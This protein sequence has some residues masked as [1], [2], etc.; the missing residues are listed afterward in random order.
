VDEVSDGTAVARSASD[1]P[2]ID[3]VVRIRGAARAKP[4]DFLRVKVTAA[5]EH[6]LEAVA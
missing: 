3:G 1:A 5:T 6:D 4:G 2:E